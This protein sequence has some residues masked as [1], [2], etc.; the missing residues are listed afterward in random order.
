[1]RKEEGRRKG[2]EKTRSDKWIAKGGLGGQREVKKGQ[3]RSGKA[4]RVKKRLGEAKGGKGRQGR[5]ED[6][7]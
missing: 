4:R 6:P 1:M 3:G 2:G 5:P 7:W